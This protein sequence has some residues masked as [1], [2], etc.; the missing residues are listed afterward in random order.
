VTLNLSNVTGQATI[1]WNT[2]ATS[3]TLAN[4]PAGSYNAV[5]SDDAGCLTVVNVVI[6]QSSEIILS[7]IDKVNPDCPN[8]Q[9]SISNDAEGGSGEYDTHGAQAPQEVL[10]ITC[11]CRNVQ[12]CYYRWCRLYFTQSII[13]NSN[14]NE[15]PDLKLKLPIFHW[16]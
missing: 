3:S 8:D 2:G 16:Q 15:K 4:V 5:I 7:A 1:L 6:D 11:C 14:D 13:L 9:K 12:C 10:L